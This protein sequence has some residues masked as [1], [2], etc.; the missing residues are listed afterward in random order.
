MCILQITPSQ[1]LEPQKDYII[2]F[3]LSKFED[4]AGNSYDS[5]YQYKFKTISGLDFTGAT[6]VLLNI[7][8]SRNHYE[9]SCPNM[10]PKA[11]IHK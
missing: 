10:V 6:G 5:V 3:N 11:K 2:E 4:A 9:I 8:L 7:G 1:R